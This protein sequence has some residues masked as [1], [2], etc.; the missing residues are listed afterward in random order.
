MTTTLRAIPR[1]RVEAVRLALEEALGSGAYARGLRVHTTLD[2]VAQA[3]V[4]EGM[5]N[6]LSEIEAGRYGRYTGAPFDPS[7]PAGVGGTDYLQGA[8]V[9]MESAT[10]E[11]LAMVGGRDFGHSRFNRATLGRR[12]VGSA[13]KPFVYLAALREGFVASQPIADRPFRLVL[14]PAVDGT[15]VPSR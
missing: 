5:N 7:T 10:G 4:E 2:P 6:R 14:E 12:P 15:G 8:M 11:V 13:F 9:V 1:I 3:A